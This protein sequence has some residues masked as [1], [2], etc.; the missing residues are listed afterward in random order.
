MMKKIL[1]M[2]YMLTALVSAG[3]E[4]GER[5]ADEGKPLLYLQGADSL[6]IKGRGVTALRVLSREVSDE[7]RQKLTQLLAQ[8]QKNT[9]EWPKLLPRVNPAFVVELVFRFPDGKGDE[10]N[11]YS[12][13]NAKY[14]GRPNAYR[15]RWVLPEESYREYRKILDGYIPPFLEW[16]EVTCE[17]MKQ[18]DKCR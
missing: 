16:K 11:V 12:I 6:M 8:A 4:G 17:E 14:K 5:A 2:L 18:F 13:G 9:S 15:Y 7:D 3:V 10:L 1:Y